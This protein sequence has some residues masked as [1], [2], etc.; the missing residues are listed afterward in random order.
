MNDWDKLQEILSIINKN[1]S[2]VNWN[3][4][5]FEDNFFNAAKRVL[6]NADMDDRGIIGLLILCHN[7]KHTKS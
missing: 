5:V 3:N 6:K 4:F 7:T 1:K 2:D